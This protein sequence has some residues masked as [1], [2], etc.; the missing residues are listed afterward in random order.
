MIYTHVTPYTH[1]QGVQNVNQNTKLPVKNKI[2]EEKK[3]KN[4]CDTRL[5]HVQSH[6][7]NQKYYDSLPKKKKNIYSQLPK[8][9][10]GPRLLRSIKAKASVSISLSEIQTFT[11]RSSTTLTVMHSCLSLSHAQTLMILTSHTCLLHSLT[12]LPLGNLQSH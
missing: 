1:A 4:T 3:K 11:Q 6:T 2:F 10:W 5:R 8:E 7:K 9:A 12:F